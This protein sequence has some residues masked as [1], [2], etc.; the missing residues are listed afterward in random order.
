[1]GVVERLDVVEDGQAGIV[2]G[3]KALAVE[4]LTLEGGEEALG[5]LVGKFERSL[6]GLRSPSIVHELWSD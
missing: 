6:P 1:M 4:Q 3:G 2:L 5:D